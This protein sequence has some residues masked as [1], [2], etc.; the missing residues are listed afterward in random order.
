MPRPEQNTKRTLLTNS[1]Y[2]FLI[3]FFPALATLAA[4]ILL[5]RNTTGDFYGRYQ[6]FWVQW[7]VLNAITCLGL[8]A[9]LL[10]YAAA[11]VR[12]L[13]AGL[14]R[15]KWL[16]LFL[17]LLVCSTLFGLQQWNG[18]A[19]FN[20]WMA[21]LFLLLNVPVAILEAYLMIARRFPAIIAGSLLYA[22]VFIAGHWLFVQSQWSFPALAYSLIIASL[23][24]VILLAVAAVNNYRRNKVADVLPVADVRSLWLHLGLYDIIQVLFRWA[25]KFILPLFL[26]PALYAVYFNGTV[27]IPFLALMLGAVG[28]ALL[29]HLSNNSNT[30]AD[31][32]KLLRLSSARLALIVFPLFFFLIAFRYELFTVILTQR[33]EAAVPLFLVSSLVIPLRAYN[34]TSILQHKGKGRIINTGALLDLVLALLLMY[35]LYLLWSLNGVALAFVISTYVQAAFYLWHTSRLLHCSM[36]DLLPLRSWLFTALVFAA[37]FFIGHSVFAWF[38]SARGTLILGCLVMTLS[39]AVIIMQQYLPKRKQ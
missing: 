33:Y 23:L 16:L 11:N 9:L 39:V 13:I 18:D 17:W 2:I 5:S 28:S 35:P 26:S 14:D 7:Q 3:R 27:D 4:M 30:D 31:R 38:C 25:D 10:T 36:T 19:V 34:F 22:I 32:I 8:P 15:Q 24:R 20:P 37:V 6:H 12:S 29:M 21:A 1:A